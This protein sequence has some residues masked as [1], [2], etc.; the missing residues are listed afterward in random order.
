M[1][2]SKRFR[3][4]LLQAD[5]WFIT[6]NMGAQERINICRLSRCVSLIHD[7]MEKQLERGSNTS[8]D[9]KR[10]LIYGTRKKN[11]YIRIGN[12]FYL[13]I[14]QNIKVTTRSNR[15]SLSPRQSLKT[16]SKII[17]LSH[18]RCFY[19]CI[20]GILYVVQICQN[21]NSILFCSKK[22]NDISKANGRWIWM[23]T[24]QKAGLT[25]GWINISF[26]PLLSQ[27]F[28]I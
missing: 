19:K 24:N 9:M 1:T 27:P 2:W 26:L 16:S 25:E 12:Y 23:I 21:K 6:L 5:I 18:L 3:R 7:N 17:S 4:K 8:F 14:T 10:R 20:T 13:H 28:W 15:R 11:M 22:R